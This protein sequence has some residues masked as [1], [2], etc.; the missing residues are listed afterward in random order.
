MATDAMQCVIIVLTPWINVND[1]VA[2]DVH[3][4]LRCSHHFRD[5]EQ[6]GVVFLNCRTSRVARLLRALKE[7]LCHRK[8]QRTVP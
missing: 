8:R 2:S 3:N 4:K 1:V 5:L 7:S 6:L